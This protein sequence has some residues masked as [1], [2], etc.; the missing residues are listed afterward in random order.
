MNKGLF[1]KALA[2]GVLVAVSF[3]A[4]LFAFTFFRRG[5]FSEKESYV[6]H[7]YLRDATGIT[8]KSRV[9]IAGIVIGEV[10]QITLEGSRARLDLRIKK[11]IDLRKDACVAK[12][13]PSA[14]LPDALLDTAPGTPAAPSMKDLPEEQREITCVKEAVS[15][16][17]LLDSL[18]KI[19]SDVKVVSGELAQTVAGS[20]G[21]IKDIIQN[22]QR[23]SATLATTA[24]DG[25]VRIQAILENTQE[26]T[27]TLRDVAEKD[28]GRY[29]AIAKNVEEA[30]S[31]LVA[32]LESAQRIVG[33][34]EPE[35]K[36]SITGVR[37]SLEKLNRSMDE[38][39]KVA[40]NIGQGKGVA[41][42][43]L[44]DERL[45]EKLGNTIEGVSDYYN[46][47]TALKLEVNLRSEWLAQQNGSKTYA[48]IKILPRPDKFYWLEIVNDPRGVDTFSNS[49]IVTEANG[50]RSTTVTSTTLNEKKLRFSAQL[51]KRYGP[52]ALRVG[53]IESSGGAGTDLYL[54]ED[55]LTVSASMFNFDRQTGV[56][57]PNLKLWADYR[58]LRFLYATVGTDDLMNR[59]Q[60][61][62][63]PGGRN[64]SFGRD[65][66]FGGGIVF[67]DDDLKTL[68]G[69]IGSS[70]GSVP[71]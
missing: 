5:G 66:F 69:A 42:K 31:R 65:V 19:A 14:L 43:L 67:T 57:Y 58:F 18:S 24:E 53:I 36:Q 55:R 61:G 17:A 7:A 1:N 34:G 40:T 10:S 13:F 30:S 2:V 47:L 63:Y 38:L 70:A 60:S 9:Q 16:D 4:F 6:V 49:T 25:S 28:Q 29:H 45:G 46:R 39:Q 51:G 26:F 64:F 15:I 35:V 54:L 48:G 20:Q 50:T 11:E 44:A 56:K 52:V 22:L 41:G 3:A 37:Q 21:S 68:I 71:R 27:G 8:W 59:W 62:R 23:L 32:L 12:R 33:E